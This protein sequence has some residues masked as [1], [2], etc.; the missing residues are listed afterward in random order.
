MTIPAENP[1]DFIEAWGTDN[2][3]VGGVPSPQTLIDVARAFHAIDEFLL[4]PIVNVLKQ[5]SANSL[6]APIVRG[7]PIPEDERTVTYADIGRLIACT[8]ELRVDCSYLL[9]TISEIVLLAHEDLQA[10]AAGMGSD[11]VLEDPEWSARMR[12]FHGLD[13]VRVDA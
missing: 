2:I 6:A 8:D 11:R 9:A 3:H 12:R 13:R 10:V 1:Y 4:A 7:T 5:V